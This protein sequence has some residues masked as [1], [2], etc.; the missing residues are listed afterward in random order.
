[1][2]HYRKEDNWTQKPSL[3]GYGK[4]FIKDSLS[5]SY[6]WY[7]SIMHSSRSRLQ[8]SHVSYSP[9]I[10]CYWQRYFS[11]NI[12]V[13]LPSHVNDSDGH[14]VPDC[15]RIYNLLLQGL[16][17]GLYIELGFLWTGLVDNASKLVPPLYLQIC[18]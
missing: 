18:D 12:E 8:H 16:A 5:W 13:E 15:L 7:W 4:Q 11:N 10:L 1:M 6:P 3:Y 2:Q 17:H 14:F 9:N